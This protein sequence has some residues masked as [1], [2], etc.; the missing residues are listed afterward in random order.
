MSEAKIQRPLSPHLQ[1]YKLPLTALMSISHRITGVGLVFGTLLVT[2]FLISAASG[3]EQYNFVMGL[4]TSLPGKIVLFLWSVGLYFHMCN[5]IRHM[6]WDMGKNFNK[7]GA[8]RSNYYVL[9]GAVSMTV[10]TWVIAC[11]CFA[12]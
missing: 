1:V 3:E 6:F 9:L 2:A 8:H 12:G 11:G 4:A 5:G 7:A 10:L